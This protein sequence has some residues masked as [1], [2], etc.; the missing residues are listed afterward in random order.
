MFNLKKEKSMTFLMFIRKAQKA[1][2][3]GI[4]YVFLIQ[5]ALEATTLPHNTSYNVQQKEDENSSNYS[6]ES[7]CDQKENDQSIDDTKGCS[8]GKPRPKPKPKQNTHVIKKLISTV[9]N[10]AC[11]SQCNDQLPEPVL[12]NYKR[13]EQNI[14]LIPQDVF[15]AMPTLM[16][17]ALEYMS[18]APDPST[19]KAQR[20]IRALLR[21]TEKHTDMLLRHPARQEIMDMLKQTSP[22]VQTYKPLIERI[23]RINDRISEITKRNIYLDEPTRSGC[24][25]SACTTIPLEPMLDQPII[26]INVTGNYCL[27]TDATTNIII[28]AENTSLDL[29][30][31]ELTGW[32]IVNAPNVT[33]K[34]G[35]INP[36]APTDDTQALTPGINIS[37]N[38]ENTRLCC[39]VVKCEDSVGRDPSQPLPVGTALRGRTGIINAGIKTF[40]L[41]CCITS[42]AGADGNTAGTVAPFDIG[43]NGGFGIQSPGIRAQISR[44]SIST[45]RGGNGSPVCIAAI[46]GRDGGNGGIGIEVVGEDSCV[47]DC[48]IITGDGGNGGFTCCENGGNGGNAGDGILNVQHKTQI[49]NCS[50]HTG[51]GGNGGEGDSGNDVSGGQGGNGGNG[52]TTNGTIIQNIIGTGNGGNG[53]DGGNPVAQVPLQAK[54]VMAVMAFL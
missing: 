31:R 20:Y 7:Q 52:I 11:N 21:Y 19:Q 4:L 36:P 32:I 13:V 23:Q 39:L 3:L 50:I 6:Q 5:S 28:N 37:S 9:V 43:G 38:G 10:D 12:R 41:D 34:N 47:F 42:G 22:A 48:K 8:C 25:S 26:G 24:C 1:I 14:L 27:V 30:G 44:C 33:V 2:V 35:K 40:I 29:N 17:Y 16:R 51:N 18:T 46:D 15:Y 54:V 49:N 53:G 45:G